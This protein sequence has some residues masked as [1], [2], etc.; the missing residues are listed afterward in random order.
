MTPRLLMNTL[1]AILVLTGAFFWFKEPAVTVVTLPSVTPA[2][3][4]Q[5][6]PAMNTKSAP[7]AG[8]I[9][10]S[11]MFSASR[12][13]PAARYTPPGADGV[14]AEPSDLA[15]KD[16][17]SAPAASP[18]RVFGTMTGPN[19]ATALIQPDSAGSSSRL[20]RE[21]ESV[22]AFR[23]EKILAASVI[24]RGPSGRLELKVE[25]REDRRE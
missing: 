14:S 25:Q 16:A 3:G 21:G 17:I 2:A 15:M 8:A 11:N 5:K 24:V 13:A 1:T 18:P 10:T 7:D 12:A 6:P 19:G 20:Y 23:I 4:G 9:V 22:G